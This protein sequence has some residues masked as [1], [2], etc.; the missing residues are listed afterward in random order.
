MDED[1]VRHL[2]RR[3][4]SE[5]RLPRTRAV[6]IWAVPSDGQTCD[7]CGEQIERN[8]QIVWAIAT[9]DWMSIQFHEDC[10]QI[11]EVERETGDAHTQQ[12]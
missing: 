8:Q 6:D 1:L 9:R 12:A 10:Y 5:G 11:W 4:L 3:K 7:G 2:V